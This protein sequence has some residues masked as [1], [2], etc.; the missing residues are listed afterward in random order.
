MRPMVLSHDDSYDAD[1]A[2][3]RVG[4]PDLDDAGNQV[5]GST[6]LMMHTGVNIHDLIDSADFP[7]EFQ[8]TANGF[9]KRVPRPASRVNQQLGKEVEVN[10]KVIA[11]FRFR[12]SVV[13][14]DAK[15]PHQGA[16][17]CGGDIED[18]LGRAGGKRSSSRAADCME[19]PSLPLAMAPFGASTAAAGNAPAAGATA[20]GSP[21]QYDAVD[22]TSLAV[23]CPRHGFAFSVSTGEGVRPAGQWKLKTYACIVVPAPR[24]P[25]PRTQTQPTQL[26]QQQHLPLDR[27]RSVQHASQQHHTISP[28]YDDGSAY[29]D[30]GGA[31]R[32]SDND[33]TMVDQHHLPFNGLGRRSSA[34][35][36]HGHGP[37][38]AM[39]Q[40]AASS[41][42]QSTALGYA[43]SSEGYSPR[44]AMT[45]NG[46]ASGSSGHTGLS[47]L[48]QQL[49]RHNSNNLQQQMLL[50]PIH[51][52]A[53][54]SRP[55]R[56][57]TR[58]DNAGGSGRLQNQFD[59]AVDVGAGGGSDGCAW[60][61]NPPAL[62]PSASS[63][64]SA[65]AAVLAGV[66]APHTA[67]ISRVH[68]RESFHTA[69]Y[70]AGASGSQPP[71]A[72]GGGLTPATA[73]P[74]DILI[75]MPA[76]HER[77]FGQDLDF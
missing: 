42:A 4:S 60:R 11:L 59:T 27:R 43:S 25:R 53:D 17:L 22:I 7:P 71:L 52:P 67:S 38:I 57:L 45:G 35:V 62:P 68:S 61:S 54:S 72:G 44:S 34:G 19:L 14:V 50:S 20:D 63:S 55:P 36:A 74:G 76:L 33:T 49:H 70:D 18:Y 48:A 56:P 9:R 8:I 6:T 26:E 58:H 16:D 37:G 10:G 21:V 69:T 12:N 1:E 31:L 23:I 28:R 13:A 41:A 24:T 15:C 29:G 5:G 66:G 46:S 32:P 51:V 64:S 3:T 73:R 65:S 30:D 47:P 2:P 39:T 75:A 77:L 40:F